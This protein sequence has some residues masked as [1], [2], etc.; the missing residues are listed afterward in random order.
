MR[1]AERA[2]HT[3]MAHEKIS[4]EKVYGSERATSGAMYLQPVQMSR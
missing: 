4:A 2:C 3:M 1:G